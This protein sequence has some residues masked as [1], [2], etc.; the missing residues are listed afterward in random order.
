MDSFLFQL[1]S[2]P[3]VA[4]QRRAWEALAVVP[5][6]M[7]DRCWVIENLGI[8]DFVNPNFPFT[9]PT[10]PPGRINSYEFI[11]DL[12]GVFDPCAP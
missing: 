8:G 5:G 11:Q 3:T 6:I 12:T 4:T 9:D 1:T 7:G 2:S 10:V